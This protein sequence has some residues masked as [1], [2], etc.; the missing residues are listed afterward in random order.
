MRALEIGPE[1]SEEWNALVAREPAFAVFQTWEWER[2][3]APAGWRAHRIGIEAGGTLVAGAQVMVQRVPLGFSVAYVP[4]GPIGSWLEGEAPSLLFGEMHRI[5]RRERVVFTRME[6]P[7]LDSEPARAA[8]ARHGFRPTDAMNFPRATLILDLATDLDAILAG[9]HRKARYNI[10]LAQR[11][12]VECHVA[13]PE[14]LPAFQQ[15]MAETAE[16]CGIEEQ[17]VDYYRSQWQV[18]APLD[19]LRLFVATYR[20]RPIAGNMSVRYGGHAIYLYGGSTREH[21]EVM[22]NHL[23]MWEAIRWAREGG[24][25][26]FDFWGVPT[27]VGLEVAAGREAPLSERT[28]DLWG[29]Y[30]FKRGFSQN[31]VLYVAAHDYVYNPVVHRLVAGRM[32]PRLS[33]LRGRLRARARAGGAGGT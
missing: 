27:E 31:V 30:R 24:C 1:R 9:L 18:L 13:G 8:L 16:R 28:D 11:R 25:R 10:R 20:G 26:T 17:S 12:G 21:R 32:L 5:A 3:K 7:L 6:P 14:D 29:P 2:V 19:R 15:L 23:L 22:P 33:R 4:R